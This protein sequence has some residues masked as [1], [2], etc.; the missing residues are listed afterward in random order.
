MELI[1][2]NNSFFLNPEDIYTVSRLNFEIKRNLENNF[3]NIFLEGE[4]S[5]F[6]CHNN[7]HFYFDL[8]DEYSKIKVVMFYDAN[9]NLNFEIKDGL[10][11]ILSGYVSVYEKRGEY[12]FVANFAQPAGIGSLLLAFEQLKAKLKDKGYFDDVFKKP[13]PVL[14]KKIGAVTSTGG[15]VIKDIISVMSKRFDN[16]HLIVRNVN[17]QGP[18]SSEE[19]CQAIDDLC[20]YGV[21]V[22][23][24]ARGGG[25]L[26]DLWAFNTEAVAEKVFKCNIP[27]ISAVGHETDFTICD[28]V[29]DI[30]AATPSVA[31]SIVVPDKN[32]LTSK[33]LLL[34]EKIKKSVADK[35]I[36]Y[37]KDLNYLV[38]RRVFKNPMVLLTSRWQDYDLTV[39]RLI[40]NIN[41]LIGFKKSNL[42]QLVKLLSIGKIKNNI[43]FK[44]TVV[45]NLSGKLKILINI[46]INELKNKIKTILQNIHAN[47]PI[48]VLEKGFS[49]VMD[50]SQKVIIKSLKQVEI[51][52][53]IKVFLH[54][55]ILLSRILDI[56]KNKLKF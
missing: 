33:I 23:I 17:V 41:D 34:F 21:D 9:K 56:I 19:I 48:S 4:V 35:I 1:N 52:D 22:I 36:H 55:G 15:A 18:S 2:S 24:I 46:R 43:R 27:V 8:K 53:E 54:D 45:I 44:Q 51:G 10:H 30:R 6:Y 5:N 37:K 40:E 26:E 7:K 39:K 50:N 32:E 13:I 14:P 11:L 12:Q 38:N 31:A 16:F 29:A 20:E 3:F 25:S 42:T 28:F 47:S 49:L